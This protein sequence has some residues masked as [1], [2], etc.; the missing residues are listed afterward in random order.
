MR[1]RKEEKKKKRRKRGAS[2][3]KKGRRKKL[4]LKLKKLLFS[5]GKNFLG[6]RRSHAALARPLD[7]GQRRVGEFFLKAFYFRS[8]EV[9]I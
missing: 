1:R 9:L 2:K 8:S 7:E 5:F 3:A 6:S 4:K